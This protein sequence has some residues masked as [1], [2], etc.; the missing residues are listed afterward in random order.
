MSAQRLREMAGRPGA[1]GIPQAHD[2]LIT[3]LDASD[4]HTVLSSSTDKMMAQ[5][6][7]RSLGSNSMGMAPVASVNLDENAVLKVAFGPG[8]HGLQAAVLQRTASQRD[9]WRAE[10]KV[11][12][13]PD[14]EFIYI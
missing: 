14:N 10:I 3:C 6:D 13:V 11:D 1:G 9:R 12:G 2:Q 5:W 4:Q 7:L 8:G